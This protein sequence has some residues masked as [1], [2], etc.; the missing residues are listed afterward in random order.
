MGKTTKLNLIIIC[1]IIVLSIN[2][3]CAEVSDVSVSR[4]IVPDSIYPGEFFEVTVEIVIGEGDGSIFG[5]LSEQY[6]AFENIQDWEM[7]NIVADPVF[8]LYKNN[9]NGIYEWSSGMR[10]IPAGTYSINYRILVPENTDSGIYTIE[11][12]W[13][14]AAH[15]DWIKVNG[16]KA[17]TLKSSSRSTDES[18]SENHLSEQQ[19]LLRMKQASQMDTSMD[20]SSDNVDSEKVIDD[21]SRQSTYYDNDTLSIDNEVTE[22][23]QKAP[24]FTGILAAFALI[25]YSNVRN[26][27]NSS[28]RAD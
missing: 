25:L 2:L 24:G 4:T 1:I 5:T 27:R 19:N 15:P 8:S 6:T 18:S 9:K 12:R 17:I 13:L 26:L 23:E 20:V 14:D 11:G 21:E 10:T 7:S 22:Q 3:C 16:S 28:N